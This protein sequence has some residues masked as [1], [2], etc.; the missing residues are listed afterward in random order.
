MR[1]QQEDV[2]KASE[3]N[4]KQFSR[5]AHHLFEARRKKNTHFSIYFAFFAYSSSI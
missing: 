5:E 1:E 3:T 2:Q 4:Q